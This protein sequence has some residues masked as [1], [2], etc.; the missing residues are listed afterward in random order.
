MLASDVKAAEDKTASNVNASK[1]NEVLRLCDSQIEDAPSVKI[2]LDLLFGLLLPES[3]WANC[4][5]LFAPLKMVQKY[6]CVNI[7]GTAIYALRSALHAPEARPIYIFIAAAI[8][9]DVETCKRSITFLPAPVSSNAASPA[10]PFQTKG[11]H[12]NTFDPR[13]MTFELHSTIPRDYC[14]ALMRARL[15]VEIGARESLA[16]RMMTEKE[17]IDCADEFVKVI[18]ELTA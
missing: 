12:P 6:E 14:F 17:R 9:K 7:R 11:G 13:A 18:R 3:E 10:S 1:D 15:T 16:S 4:R 5:H 8:L 2:F